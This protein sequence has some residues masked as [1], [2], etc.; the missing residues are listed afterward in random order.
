MTPSASNFRLASEFDAFLFT[1]LGEDRNGLPLSVVSLLGRMDLDPLGEAASL[2]SLPAEAAAQRLATLLAALP[3]SSLKK[4]DAGSMAARLIEQLPR[5]AAADDQAFG[6]LRVRDMVHPHVLMTAILFAIWTIWVLSTPSPTGR[7]D[8]P[9]H[10]AT[11]Q[12][13]APLS[14]P[15]PPLTTGK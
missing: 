1:A 5:R 4:S 14:G 3:D 11:A 2:A 7:P 10:A 12:A 9:T 15:S 13:P 6:T 8:A